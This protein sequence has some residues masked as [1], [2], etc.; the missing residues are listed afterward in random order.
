MPQS[1]RSPTGMPSTSS[2]SGQRCRREEKLAP[3]RRV[4]QLLDGGGEHLDD[5]VRIRQPREIRWDAAEEREHLEVRR[6]APHGR[7][8]GDHA[9]DARV[10]AD[11]L[12]GF[13]QRSREQARI[14]VVG[15]PTGKREL[16]TVVAVIRADD[17]DEAQQPV[18][19]AEDGREHR[20]DAVTTG[21][22]HRA[23]C[24]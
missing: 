21:C 24:R 14:G 16:P 3:D 9:H 1:T 2:P 17:Q 11:L 5:L 20:C 7:Q 22:R 8:L 10:E 18:A 4:P 6:A 13:A 12:L 23:M 19:I 15:A